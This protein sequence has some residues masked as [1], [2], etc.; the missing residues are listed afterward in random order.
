[1]PLLL[2]V[3]LIIACLPL[4]W[5]GPPAGVGVRGS[6][7]LTGSVVILLLITSRVFSLVTVFRVARHP[8]AREAI[9]RAHSLR[10]LLFVFLNLGGFWSSSSVVGGAGPPA[11]C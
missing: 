2:L 8:E 5:P 1:M 10:R 3:S 4:E 7:V 6:A 11:S 9:G